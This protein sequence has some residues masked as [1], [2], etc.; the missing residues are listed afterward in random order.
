MFNFI[1]ERTK[2]SETTFY[3]NFKIKQKNNTVRELVVSDS[4]AAFSSNKLFAIAGTFTNNR[5]TP[6]LSIS[7]TV[8]LYFKNLENNSS[9]VSYKQSYGD[10][11]AYNNKTADDIDLLITVS[12]VN[13]GSYIYYVSIY[14]NKVLSSSEIAALFTLLKATYGE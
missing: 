13:Y 4:G 10:D 5:I 14:K 3:F 11:S 6:Q 2:Q 9:V 1:L 12:N 7:D 8:K